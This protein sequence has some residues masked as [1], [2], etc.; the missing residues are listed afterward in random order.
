MT[1]EI[2]LFHFVNSS[3][4]QKYWKS[5][6]VERSFPWLDLLILFVDKD[7][8]SSIQIRNLFHNLKEILLLSENLNLKS[9]FFVVK[10]RWQLIKDSKHKFLHLPEKFS[11]KSIV[12]LKLIENIDQLLLKS[13]FELI[14]FVG[15]FRVVKD[16]IE[17]ALS[18]FCWFIWL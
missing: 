3:K 5:N 15:W 17:T 13:C 2:Q 11:S 9:S 1:K 10:D 12:K 6:L 18:I 14:E 7:L 8:F 4:L 16:E